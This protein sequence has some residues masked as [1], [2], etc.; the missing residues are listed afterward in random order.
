M[1]QGY[2]K[3]IGACFLASLSAVH[4]ASAPIASKPLPPEDVARIDAAVPTRAQV[5]PLKPRRLLVFDLN[6]NYGGHPSARHAAEAFRLMGE[7]TGAFKIEV[8]RDPEVFRPESLRRFD[9]VFFNNTVGN[10][11]TD[12]VLRRSLIEFVVAGGGLMGT[13]GT[14]VAFTQWPGAIEDWPEFAALIGARGANHRDSDERVFVKL[15]DPDHPLN[16]G[17]GGSGFEFRDE[18]FRVHEP[19]SRDRVRV[20]LSFDTEKTDMNQGQARGNCVRA[21]NDYAIAWLRNYGRGRTLYCTIAH[22]PY[23]FWDPLMLRFYLRAAQFVLGD[24]DAPTTPSARLDA[25][26]RAQE[27]LG[28]RSGFDLRPSPGHSL[29]AAIDQAGAHGFA[30]T[31][32]AGSPPLNSDVAA[33]FGPGLSDA[34][35]SAVRLRLDA[36][37]LRLLT[38][39]PDHAPPDLAGW[40]DLF[41]FARKL[42]VETVAAWP[43]AGHLPLVKDLCDEFDIRLALDPM[44]APTHEARPAPGELRKKCD[45]LSPRIGVCGDVRGWR[46]VG[47]DPIDAVKV[48]GSRLFIVRMTRDD[49]NDTRWIE[50]IGRLRLKPTLFSWTAAGAG[51]GATQRF[52]PAIQ[53]FQ[54]TALKLVS[55]IGRTDP[56]TAPTP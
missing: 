32:I 25:A 15:D 31:A 21:D 48:L 30:Y 46:G 39:A 11:F 24:L 29:F 22:N 6:V 35:L 52:D 49:V 47:V 44:A 38:Y 34:E 18:F 4:V 53:A 14:A 7:K 37:G 9:A 17:F 43:I 20:L 56:S 40:R 1:D 26:T 23:V 36:A 28:W 42:G 5:T 54:Q 27:A 3:S 8:S 45:A 10:L 2:F 50:E 41:T 55:G 19:Y 12:P 16:N 33:T 13:H 51:Q